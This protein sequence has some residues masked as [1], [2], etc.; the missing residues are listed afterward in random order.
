M[1]CNQAILLMQI[2]RGT[3]ISEYR[4]GTYA[5]DLAYLKDMGLVRFHIDGL[6]TMP[7]GDTVVKN[8]LAIG[9]ASI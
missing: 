1:T 6:Y 7:A 3:I 8:M 2:Y 9:N 4:I 5:D